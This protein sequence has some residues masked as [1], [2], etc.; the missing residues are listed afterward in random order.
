NVFVTSN[1]DGN[2]PTGNTGGV[3][4]SYTFD[5]GA[6]WHPRYFATGLDTK[7]DP[8]CCDV[9][10]AFDR[11]GNLWFTY[12]DASVDHAVI[13]LSTNGG[14]SFRQVKSFSGVF[15]QPKLAV[16]NNTVWAVWENDSTRGNLSASP[17]YFDRLGHFQV[18]F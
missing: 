12:F 9:S 10:A 11:F 6:T 13:T 18:F 17:A 3:M 14:V 5:R 4:V 1:A 15:D 16:G 7:F 8:A 2:L